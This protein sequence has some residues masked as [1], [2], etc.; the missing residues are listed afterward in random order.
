VR[1]D[2]DPR[3]REKPGSPTTGGA[4]R[5]AAAVE[6]PRAETWERPRTT[7]ACFDEV[8]RRHD[9][10][11]CSKGR[12]RQFAGEEPPRKT[13]RLDQPE[14]I[15]AL[16]TRHH[17][18][19]AALHA[20]CRGAHA[21]RRPS[22]VMRCR[23]TTS[24]ASRSNRT[25]RSSVFGPPERPPTTPILADR[26]ERAGGS[27]RQTPT[28]SSSKAEGREGGGRKGRNSGRNRPAAQERSLINRA[29]SSIDKCMK[30]ATR[31]NIHTPITWAR[32]IQLLVVH[33][34]NEM[35]RELS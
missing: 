10:P 33:R 21:V 25:T 32:L 35:S 4:R 12:Q 22:A 29:Q 27:R 5:P 3:A 15:V 9:N 30:H 24:N 18:Y 16:P 2:K 13:R 20:C 26:E 17:Y 19:C 34:S 31:P 23:A 6:A 14:K 8:V 28:A 1:P 11:D 7:S